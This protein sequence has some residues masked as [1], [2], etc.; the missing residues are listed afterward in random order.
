[1]NI[2]E[3]TKAIFA[4]VIAALL[5]V[6]QA[7]VPDV[8]F[9]IIL[10]VVATLAGV[11]GIANVRQMFDQ[12]RGALVSKTVVGGLLVLLGFLGDKLLPALSVGEPWT[13]IVGI[14]LK[15]IGTILGTFGIIKATEKGVVQIK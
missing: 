1:M 11:F 13:M 6:A 9:E 4:I 8:T 12:Y 14:L 3:K 10:Q 5:M 7:F 15:A 2:P